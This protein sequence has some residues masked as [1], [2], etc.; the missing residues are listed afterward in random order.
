MVGFLLASYAQW[1]RQQPPSA[2]SL[3]RKV[4]IWTFHSTLFLD[5]AHSL[6]IS[7]SAYRW[8]VAALMAT[9]STNIIMQSAGH[10]HRIRTGYYVAI[11]Q[12]L[13]IS[14]ALNLFC[15]ALALDRIE[16]SNST[17]ASSKKGDEEATGKRTPVTAHG[18]KL[19]PLWTLALVMMGYYILLFLLPETP[20]DYNFMGLVLLT[21]FALYVVSLIDMPVDWTIDRR[22]AQ[23]HMIAT[24]QQFVILLLDPVWSALRGWSEWEGWSGS[25]ALVWDLVENAAV[26]ALG[27]DFV[28]WVVSLAIMQS[29]GLLGSAKEDEDGVIEGTT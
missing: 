1:S 17:A 2:H 12:I 7:A 28:I 8:I 16:N 4:Y 9:M 18:Q 23:F 14:F 3:L 19:M 24:S 13:P 27:V 29:Y 11:A 10:R 6:C 21:R 22:I 25:V 26:A 5:F 15:S 20:N